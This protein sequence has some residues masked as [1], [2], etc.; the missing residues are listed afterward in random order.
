MRIG[1]Y[2]VRALGGP[3]GCLLMIL[4]SILLSVLCTVVVNLALR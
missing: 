4:G 3:T 1:D 2:E